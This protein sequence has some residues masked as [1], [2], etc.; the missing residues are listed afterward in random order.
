[1]W[2]LGIDVSEGNG[3]L[4][5]EVIADHYPLILFAYIRASEGDYHTD[6]QFKANWAESKLASD[7]RFKARGIPIL[8][9]PYH[10]FHPENNPVKQAVIFNTTV[11]MD[12]GDLP[13]V[14][15]MEL[16]NGIK[17]LDI[18]SG[19]NTFANELVAQ[20]YAGPWIYTRTSFIQEFMTI[21]G[22]KWASMNHYHYYLAQWV[23]SGVEDTRP[24]AL[25]EGMY[26]T[27]VLVHQTTNKAIP[28]GQ[29][30]GTLDLDR[31]LGSLDALYGYTTYKNPF[32]GTLTLEQRVLALEVAAR[33]H[34]WEV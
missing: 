25:P 13:P 19:V 15:D 11:G 10:A 6:S 2:E 8:R 12:Q 7:T 14:I 20:F 24:L 16:A 27:N 9:Q 26:T 22:I 1:M 31:W 17:P 28:I 33:A 5:W 29:A 21:G 23:N 32:S 3:T 18:I 34:G 30:G 4:D